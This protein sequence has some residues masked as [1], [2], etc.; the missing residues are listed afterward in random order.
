MS[1]DH[2]NGQA[3][4]AALEQP[5]QEIEITVDGTYFICKIPIAAGKAMVYGAIELF[6]EEAQKTFFA[7]ERREV[8]EREKNKGLLAKLKIPGVR[9]I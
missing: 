8:M 7:M 1:S 3:K 9:T 4:E 6:R 5:K 2:G